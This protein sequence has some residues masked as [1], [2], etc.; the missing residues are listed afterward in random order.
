MYD[1]VRTPGGALN[2]Q[3]RAAMGSGH[4]WAGANEVFWNC[5]ADSIKCDKP[6]TAQNYAIGCIGRKL[7]GYTKKREFGH[8]ESH[9]TPVKPRSLY[10][11][12]LKKRLGSKG[13]ANVAV[14][15]QLEKFPLEHMK[16]YVI[17]PDRKVNMLMNSHFK[18][19]KKGRISFWRVNA[20]GGSA[21]KTKTAL[22]TIE[23][24]DGKKALHAINDKASKLHIFQYMILSES[25]EKCQIIFDYKAPNGTKISVSASVRYP[26]T[27]GK[28][29]RKTCKA[30]SVVADG[31]WQKYDEAVAIPA[32][33]TGKINLSIIASGQEIS[34]ADAMFIELWKNK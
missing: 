3:D 17:E 1:N 7:R 15:N 24:P 31:S 28:E 23:G 11:T 16:K 30:K 22:S 6:E 34:L 8:W 5:I 18:L 20:Y 9:G 4:G 12:Q 26:Q 29:A 10:L 2:V 33:I 25:Y 19:S 13:L 32:G 14:G 21:K 27:T